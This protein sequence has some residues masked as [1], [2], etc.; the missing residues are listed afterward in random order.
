MLWPSRYRWLHLP[1]SVRPTTHRCSPFVRDDCEGRLL[2]TGLGLTPSYGPR[3][4]LGGEGTS[5]KKYTAEQIVSML[6][7]AEVLFGKGQNVAAD[8]WGL[9][10]A[11][12]RYELWCKQ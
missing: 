8:G 10:I 9:R 6:R 2:L 3:F 12:P 1:S 4:V 5:E 7:E 11:D